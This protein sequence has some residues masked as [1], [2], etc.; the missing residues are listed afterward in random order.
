M[1]LSALEM[2]MNRDAVGIKVNC[3]AGY[4]A[5]QSPQ[6]FSIGERS[7]QVVEILDRWLS[8]EQRYFKLRTEDSGIYILHYLSKSDRWEI[9]M[10][11]CGTRLDTRLSST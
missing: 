10:Y 5:E 11:D 3:Y 2:T 1:S 8:P 9:S 4:R 7:L 6:R